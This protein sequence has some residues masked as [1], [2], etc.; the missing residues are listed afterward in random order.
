MPVY[1]LLDPLA[2]NRCCVAACKLLHMKQ[3]AQHAI[4]DTLRLRREPRVVVGP[5]IQIDQIAH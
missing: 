5:L 1:D 3:S 4:V 2:P